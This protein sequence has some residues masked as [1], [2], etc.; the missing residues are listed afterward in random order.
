VAN[1]SSTASP[2]DGST[3]PLCAPIK[4]AVGVAK[5]LLFGS[6]ATP[7]VVKKVEQQP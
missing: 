1:G 6:V 3:Y 2:P 4:D 5:P 7:D